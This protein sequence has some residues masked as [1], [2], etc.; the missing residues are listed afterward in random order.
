M[1][2][3]KAVGR[4]DFLAGAAVAATLTIV[5][6]GSARGAEAASRLEVG[7]IGCGGRGQWIADL[8]EKSAPW[9]VV[10]THDYFADR[11]GGAGKRFGVDA[12]RCFSG[13]A[14]YRRL[15][16]GKLDAVAIESPPYFHPEQAAAAVEAGKHVYVAKPIAV[17]VPGC[18]TIA[19]AGRRATEK[20]LAFLVDFQSRANEFFR[21][22]VKWVHDGNIGKVVLIQ[23]NYFTGPIGRSVGD[24]SPEARLRGWTSDIPLSGDII[25]EQN[26]HA[27]DIASW[28]LNADPIKAIGTGGNTLHC[29]NGDC[30]DHFAV[31]YYCPNDIVID[32]SSTQCTHSR[33][34]IACWVLGQ[35]GTAE[36]HYGGNVIVRG[37]QTYRGGNTGPIY[38]QG[39][40]T[41]IQDFHKNITAGNFANETVAPSVRSN[42]TCILGR[43][44]AY[45]GRMVTWDEMIKANEKLDAKLEGMKA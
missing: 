21:G 17:D 45:T 32:F 43:T 30:Y 44:A 13:L 35:R 10:A 25:V 40:V 24:K 23:A 22:A 9:K 31:L 28:F 12:A 34:D 19:Q 26:I 36:T 15:L 29:H 33:E 27:L 5:A 11:S 16:E 8:F 2:S 41:N 4:R 42:L 18:T 20:K 1:S 7:L 14:G 38:Q 6:P 37:Q 3:E 39:A